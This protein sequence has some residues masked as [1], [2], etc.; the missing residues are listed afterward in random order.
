MDFF[1]PL[2][3]HYQKLDRNH[4]WDRGMFSRTIIWAFLESVQSCLVPIKPSILAC[5]YTQKLLSAL[6]SVETLKHARFQDWKAQLEH[7]KRMFS[8]SKVLQ[9]P[10]FFY[11]FAIKL[12]VAKSVCASVRAHARARMQWLS[13]LGF[14]FLH[15]SNKHNL[16]T[17]LA[18]WKL[19]VHQCLYRQVCA[20]V[21]L[22]LYCS[23]NRQTTGPQQECDDESKLSWGKH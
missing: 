18:W 12:A 2:W 8:L 9:M 14:V 23:D 16:N 1:F 4:F 22:Q 15:L 5:L 13:F 21:H 11:S 10:R 3:V 6:W 19:T 17:I 20:V 7:C